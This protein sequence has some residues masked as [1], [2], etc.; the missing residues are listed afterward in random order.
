MMY[1]IHEPNWAINKHGLAHYGR[2]VGRVFL[3]DQFT[4]ERI[5]S[6]VRE[7]HVR[8]IP[9]D[10][11]VRIYGQIICVRSA[12]GEYEFSNLYPYRKGDEKHT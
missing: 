9:A 5:L 3:G 11:V 4:D 1:S 2:Y 6:I 7:H 8:P 10:A 12:D